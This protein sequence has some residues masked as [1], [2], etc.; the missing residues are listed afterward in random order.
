MA[1]VDSLLAGA[2]AGLVRLEPGAAAAAMND[3]ALL[4][5]DA[6]F[7]RHAPLGHHPERPERLLAARAGLQGV[8]ATFEH[9]SCRPATD[10]EL[11]RVHEP[12]FVAALGS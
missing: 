12:R 1:A 10:D 4:V 3:G 11:G 6:R 9:V 8:A 5:D 2:R 7:D